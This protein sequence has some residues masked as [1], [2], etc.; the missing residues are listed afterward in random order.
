M[1]PGSQEF[2]KR[3]V[4]TT[5]R[6]SKGVRH[7]FRLKRA[8]KTEAYWKIRICVSAGLSICFA[9]LFLFL[10]SFSGSLLFW[11][12]PERVQIMKKV[13]RNNRAIDVTTVGGRIKKLR[14]DAGYT[15]E[16]LAARLH[17]EGKSA[18]SNYEN[19]SRGVS[20]EMLMQLSRLFH[21]SADYIL[22]GDSPDNL[23][24]IVNEAI[25]ILNN[26][27]TD[28]AKKSA[29]EL[30]RQIQILEG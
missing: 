10:R 6:C 11:K 19:N 12:A 17:L 23:D 9:V 18:I 25:E 13:N 2:V 4:F 27:K 8:C 3:V 21:V 1:T 22:N 28:K 20:A 29:L 5:D 26:L 30:L 14:T 24:P 16:E 7:L 15:Q